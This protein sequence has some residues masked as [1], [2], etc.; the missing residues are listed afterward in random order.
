M[1]GIIKPIGL[2]IDQKVKPI[3]V[4]G[5]RLSEDERTPPLPSATAPA[6]PAPAQAVASAP[7]I[8]SAQA[9][10]VA[11]AP[12]P[13]AQPAAPPSPRFGQPGYNPLLHSGA[14][15]A[16]STSISKQIAQAPIDIAKGTARG[17][18]NIGKIPLQIG[19]MGADLASNIYGGL[20][21]DWYRAKDMVIK[22]F[23]PD[24]YARKEKEASEKRSEIIGR[25]GPMIRLSDKMEAGREAINRATQT[26]WEKADPNLSFKNQ[27][28]RYVSQFVS[29]AIPTYAAAIAGTAITKDPRIAMGLFASQAGGN[30]YESAKKEGMDV[31]EAIG[32]A[33]LQGGWSAISERIPFDSMLGNQGKKA[34]VRILKAGSTEGIQEV[35]QTVGE[36]AIEKFGLEE[37]KK[38][39]EGWIEALIGGVL[40]GGVGGAVISGG[41]EFSPS[42]QDVETNPVLATPERPVLI[43]NQ[44]E[45]ARSEEGVRISAPEEPAARVN[46]L[47]EPERVAQA[48]TQAAAQV[49]RPAEPQAEAARPAE[50]PAAP[51]DR[52]TQT[53]DNV[54]RTAWVRGERQ[55]NS[56]GDKFYSVSEDVAGDYG[57][58]RGINDVERPKNPLVVTDKTELAEVIGY[59]GDPLAEPLDTPQEK[60]FDVLAKAYAQEKG[61][62]A[63]E[64][65]SGS[66]GEGELHVFA[67]SAAP[68]AAR[69]PI[70]QARDEAGSPR[71]APPAEVPLASRYTPEQLAEM[72]AAQ[73]KRIGEMR[74]PGDG[75]AKAQGE[76]PAPRT[77]A[78]LAKPAQEPARVAEPS[79]EPS[80]EKP[81]TPLAKAVAEAPQAFRV[82]SSR[83]NVHNVKMPDGTTYPIRAESKAEAIAKAQA[84]ANKVPLSKMNDSELRKRADELGVPYDPKSTAKELR[85][86]IR[87]VQQGGFIDVSPRAPSKD[88]P[89]FVRQMKE[90]DRRV[91]EWQKRHTRDAISALRSEVVDR[92][93]DV[94]R[95]LKGIGANDAI[96]RLVLRQGSG[97]EA[98]RQFRVAEKSITDV[99]PTRDRELF[100]YYL[101]AMRVVE[102]TQVQ[103]ERGIELKS[104]MSAEDAKRFLNDDFVKLPQEQQDAVMGAAKK[105]WGVMREQLDALY[106]EGL[107]GKE[108]YEAIATKHQFY[109]PRRFVE[110]IDPQTIKPKGEMRHDSGVDAL[111]RGSESAMAAD[112]MYLM[113]HVITRTQ[114]RLFRNRAN[115]ALYDTAISSPEN[116]VARVLGKNETPTRTEDSVSVFIAGQ[117]VR[118][119]M[120][121]QL[122]A[123]WDGLPPALSR[124]MAAFLQWASGTKI[125][126]TLATGANPEFAISNLPRDAMYAWFTSGQYS[127]VL[128]KA[129]GQILLDYKR[130]MRDAIKRT[131]AYTDYVKEGGGMDFL[132][133][134]GMTRKPGIEGGHR[135]ARKIGDILAWAGETSEI[136]TR[137]AVRNRAIRNGLSPEEATY[138][139]RN[140][141][142]FSQ[143]GTFAKAADN[144]I[145]YLNAAIQGTRGGFRA[146]K[147][148]PKVASFK[149]AQLAAI[150]Y[151]LAQVA[152]T[153]TP[154]LWDSINAREKASKWIIPLP[155]TRKDK[156]GNDRHAYIA[157][158][159]DQFQQVFAAIG[160]SFVDG[161]RGN[162]WKPQVFDSL[163][164]TIPV[165]ASSLVPPIMNAYFAYA[166]NYD[167]WT[168]E[169]VWQGYED[170]SPSKE[171]S[172]QTPEIAVDIAELASRM[173]VEISPERL[174]TATGKVVPTSNP[175]G[176]IMSSIYA[177]GNPDPELG[178]TIVE[179][180]RDIP[181]IRR[182]LRFSRPSN[183][184]KF[185]MDKAYQYNVD[186][187]GMTDLQAREAIKVAER[188]R[189]DVRYPLNIEADKIARQAVRGDVSSDDLQKWID[190]VPQEERKRV[191][192]RIK[193]QYKKSWKSPSEIIRIVTDPGVANDPSK[194]ANSEWLAKYGM[195]GMTAKDLRTALV[196]EAREQGWNTEMYDSKGKLTAYGQRKLRLSR[197]I[198]KHNIE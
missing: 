13:Q 34:F 61:H 38:L 183:L 11:A 63:I 112:P 49:E 146:F 108:G 135:L 73:E 28:I 111:D 136:A 189:A 140:M 106:A 39:T 2:K 17:I 88:D 45:A 79:Q 120:P 8:P 3:R 155:W 86:R 43:S 129:I 87:A 7:V 172:W 197:F 116:S 171:Q 186:V 169:N 187:A 90:N 158:P 195:D 14:S 198:R 179:K 1:D 154:E 170:I 32:Y 68:E 127:S 83:G 97:A 190:S 41:S 64:Y 134:Q 57:V 15:L 66:L 36:N 162:P 37:G 85:D 122:A 133:T 151:G 102:A 149:A 5:M 96:R 176:S 126:K 193:A 78:D 164:S 165:E 40:L 91:H 174:A 118:M 110:F 25:T 29:E 185:T 124:N 82:T 47:L 69:P 192:S 137:L 119:A 103:A 89:P 156:E 74:G 107:I 19:E 67:P 159:K 99:L 4:V 10:P 130:S 114:N 94:K 160:Q 177:T 56:G 168:K 101:Q 141:L 128:P 131:G 54:S 113:A 16:P 194:Q 109:S 21:Q 62:D 60:K 167:T 23:A 50:Q 18:Q 115:K 161:V 188:K 182:I 138:V 181:G 92:Q 75:E 191:E 105:Y 121:K 31:N 72:K 81:A 46:P 153:F 51:E 180:L 132:T 53:T 24:Y 123:E 173:G 157:I 147:E 139:A 52:A 59:K 55:E 166:E 58:V 84:L 93:A 125:L 100:K 9:S 152:A 104:P 65:M 30:A 95:A 22:K 76:K 44:P 35:I 6:G 42:N 77:A 71:Q 143:G 144:V 163:M 20:R 26:G 70:E 178:R 148:N 33:L 196:K 142:D 150:G 80:Q 184:Q 175:L 117:E 12:L 27:P 98:A 48:A 145:P